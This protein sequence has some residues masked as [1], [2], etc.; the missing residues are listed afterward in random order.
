MKRWKKW[1]IAGLVVLVAA[2]G[3]VWAFS[4]R[5]A[6]PPERLTLTET[7]FVQVV[8]ATG[9]L[10][11]ARTVQVQ[12]LV[13]G[14]LLTLPYEEGD[15]VNTGSVLATLDDGDARQRLAESRSGL[16]L[17][18]ARARSLSELMVPVTQ[19]ELRQLALNREQLELTLQRQEVLYAQGAIPLE[20]LEETRSQLALLDSRIRSAEVSLASRRSGGAEAAEVAATVNQ[21]RSSLETL[22]RELEKYTL[23]APFD[24]IVLERLAEPGELMQPGTVLLVLA[25]DD[26]FYAEVDLDERSMGLIQT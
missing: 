5:E 7:P 20:P 2:A 17:A 12:S 23:T 22:E 15:Q 18:Q 3:A 6:A 13:T 4:S 11:P 8:S 24:G 9:R 26:G 25:A 14:R 10:V 21:A 16:T 1:I 19:E